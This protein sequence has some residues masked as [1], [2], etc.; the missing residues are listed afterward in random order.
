MKSVSRLGR[1][2]GPMVLAGMTLGLVVPFG[3]VPNAPPTD[4]P[5]MAA[6]TPGIAG[7]ARLTPDAGGW[8]RPGAWVAVE[9]PDP[10]ALQPRR[11]APTAPRPDLADCRELGAGD[12]AGE[13]PGQAV[14]ADQASP[15]AH[16]DAGSWWRLDPVLDGAGWLIGQHLELGRLHPGQSARAWR[17]LALPAESFVSGPTQ[18]RLVVGADDGTTSRL[19]LI[20]LD[21]GCRRQVAEAADVVRRAILSIDGGAIYESRVDRETREDLGI[22]QRELAASTQAR[23]LLGPPPVDPRFGPTWST[24]LALDSTGSRLVVSSCGA[25][26]CRHRIADLATGEVFIHADP[27]V[28]E[29]VGLAGDVVYAR[30]AC[31]GLPCPILK[32]ASDAEPRVVAPAADLATLVTGP[33]GAHLVAEAPGGERVEVIDP[34]DGRVLHVVP[35]E[36]G[37]RIVPGADRSLSGLGLDRD[38]AD[39][40]QLV[41]LAPGGRIAAGARIQLID[42]RRAAATALEEVLP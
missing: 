16:P 29:L 42:P 19:F 2:R 17:S 14:G 35:L 25:G 37:Q 34:V 6:P 38:P 33:E 18:G 24:T 13:P 27:D 28:G 21:R 1:I 8:T 5:T 30:A 26:A 39:P 23:Q 9:Q 3:A 36:P 10:R 12:P 22:W 11:A 4:P 41:V 32:L 20:D 31:P 15:N 40:G 7:S